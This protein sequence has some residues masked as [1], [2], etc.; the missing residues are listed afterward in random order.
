LL[1]LRLESTVRTVETPSTHLFDLVI[2]RQGGDQARQAS[3]G[4][5]SKGMMHQ[6]LRSREKRERER[7]REREKERGERER[8]KPIPVSA[9]SLRI[10]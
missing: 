6:K 4:D 1:E 10:Y 5:Q 9:L 3:S 2:P 7:E 8:G